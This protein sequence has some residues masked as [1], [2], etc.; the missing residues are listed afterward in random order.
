MDTPELE[1][2]FTEI[3]SLAP[4]QQQ[5]MAS[6]LAEMLEQMRAAPVTEDDLQDPEY[7]AYVEAA[8][9]AAEEDRLEGRVSSLAVVAARLKSGIAS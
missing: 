3:R 6:T 1:I 9:D 2:V 4:E 5:L 8:L 7:R